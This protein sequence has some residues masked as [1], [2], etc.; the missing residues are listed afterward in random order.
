MNSARITNFSLMLLILFGSLSYTLCWAETNRDFIPSDISDVTTVD[1]N[2]VAVSL[3]DSVELSGIVHSVNLRPVNPI[4]PSFNGLQMTMIDHNNNGIQLFVI[5]GMLDPIPEIGDSLTVKGVIQQFYGRICLILEIDFSLNICPGHMVIHSSNN[6]LTDPLLLDEVLGEPV[7]SKIVKASN[8]IYDST[9]RINSFMSNGYNIHM[10]N[11]DG[12]YIIYIDDD[13]EINYTDLENTDVTYCITGI[14]D[15]ETVSN[16]PPFLDCYRVTPSL[17]VD[18]VTNTTSSTDDSLIPH[19]FAL[20]NAFPNPFNPETTI[21]FSL[22]QDE[23]IDL[24]IYNVKGQKIKQLGRGSFREGQ[25][26]ITWFGT[27]D[28]DNPI[29]SG[30]YFYKLSIDGKLSKI[31]K[32]T[33][34][35]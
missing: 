2:G 14:A 4:I 19:N 31:R 23:N 18:I 27:D 33:L 24:A 5:N 22:Q 11:D 12:E 21:S 7:E 10:H 29:S 28:N 15:Q 34:I 13:T 25:H 1:N 8:L 17:N 3:G 26:S 6:Q 9:S 30:T 32:C 16:E 20:G 35:K